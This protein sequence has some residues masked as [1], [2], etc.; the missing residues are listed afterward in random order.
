MYQYSLNGIFPFTILVNSIL[1]TGS[2]SNAFKVVFCN[3]ALSSP[4]SSLIVS[5]NLFSCFA[6]EIL[7]LI[8]RFVVP[9]VGGLKN[10]GS[11]L[12]ALTALKITVLASVPVF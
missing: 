2:P 12:N 7:I 8:A 4:S 11:L 9:S 1:K 10:E 3:N 6:V 5:S